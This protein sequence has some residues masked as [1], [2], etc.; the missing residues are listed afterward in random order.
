MTEHVGHVR[1]TLDAWREQGADRLDPVRFHLID[2]LERR[3]ARHDG[4]ARR[5][6][7][8][9]LEALVQGYAADVARAANLG[10]E[11]PVAPSRGA[12]GELAAAL[13]ERAVSRGGD[14]HGEDATTLPAERAVHEFRRIWSRVRVESQLK[15]S[16]EQVPENAGPLN[17]GALVHR[18][19]ALMQELS[20]GYLQHFLAYVDALSCMEQLT[21]GVPLV[22][23]ASPPAAPRKR[24]RER[25]RGR[26]ERSGS[27]TPAAE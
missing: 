5:L 11:A 8:Q 7:E 20:P 2:A 12:L 13:A 10:A 1:A 17:S 16:L 9:R 21:G 24:T 4:D 22:K 23:E 18:S 3:T 19:I 26:R 14:A 27:D 15:Q 25:A 6:L